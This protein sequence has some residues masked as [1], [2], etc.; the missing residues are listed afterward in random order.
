MMKSLVVS[1]TDHIS[2]GKESSY[3]LIL[4]MFYVSIIAFIAAVALT[5]IVVKLG[6]QKLMAYCVDSGCSTCSVLSGGNLA[7]IRNFFDGSGP[8]A[9]AIPEGLL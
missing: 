7:A 6:I 5:V 9:C 2:L 1:L 8:F 4:V 3:K